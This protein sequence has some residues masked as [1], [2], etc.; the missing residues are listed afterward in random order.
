MN[1][2]FRNASAVRHSIFGIRYFAGGSKRHTA[3]SVK[4]LLPPR[5]SRGTSLRIGGSIPSTL[6][7]L[8]NLQN[9]VLAGNQLSGSFPPGPGNLSGLP[10]MW[11]SRQ[12]TVSGRQQTVWATDCP[13]PTTHCRLP[14]VDCLL[15]AEDP[16]DISGEV[17]PKNLPGGFIAAIVFCPVPA[18][19]GFSSRRK[20]DGGKYD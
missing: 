16:A 5:R 2:E 11:L 17:R 8:S 15:P 4:Q 20:K 14:T 18:R 7:S 19:I 9:V 3:G 10:G 12:Q 1:I 13:L 6:G